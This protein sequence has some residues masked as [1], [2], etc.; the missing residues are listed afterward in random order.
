MDICKHKELCGGCIHQG[1]SYEQQLEEKGNDVSMLIS[2][3]EIKVGE[4]LGIGKSG[5]VQIPQ[6]N[7]IYIRGYC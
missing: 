6:Q 1:K 2:Q 3:K 7:G 5:A 4:Y